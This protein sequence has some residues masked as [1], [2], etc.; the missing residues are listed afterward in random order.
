[1]RV[2]SSQAKRFGWIGLFA[3]LALSCAFFSPLRARVESIPAKVAKVFQASQASPTPGAHPGLSGP[4]VAIAQGNA[5][6]IFSSLLAPGRM[7]E[8]PRAE[9]LAAAEERFSHD[10]P[11]REAQGSPALT[12]EIAARL[13]ILK[14][15]APFSSEPAVQDF[16]RRR[17]HHRQE[18]W[19]VERQA[20]R[21]LDHWLSSLPEREYFHFLGHAD[22]RAVAYAHVSEAD[23]LGQVLAEVKERNPAAAA[24]LPSYND[25][26]QLICPAPD[27]FATLAAAVHWHRKSNAPFSCDDPVEGK[28]GRLLFLLRAMDFSGTTPP[29]AGAVLDNLRNPW[30]YLISRVESL[31]VDLSQTTT[32]AY[33]SKRNIRLGAAFFQESPLEA[34]EALIHEAR[35]SDADDPGHVICVQGDIP[36]VDGG[37]DE[38]LS[39]GPKAGGYSY[40]VFFWTQLAR[41]SNMNLADREF[42]YSQALASISQRFNHL[43]P[44]LAQFIDGIVGLD[45]NAHLVFL[46]PFARYSF[47][48]STMLG[49]GNHIQKLAVDDRSGGVLLFTQNLESLVWGFRQGILPYF[50][51]LVGTANLKVKFAGKLGIPNI[52]NSFT[53][54]AFIDENQ[55]V[56]YVHLKAETGERVLEEFPLGSESVKPESFCM[57]THGFNYFLSSDH[58][59]FTV[60]TRAFENRGIFPGWAQEKSWDQI[61]CGVLH[62][63]LFGISDGQ[64]YRE[65]YILGGDGVSDELSPNKTFYPVTSK[66]ELSTL[67]S[68]DSPARIYHE[69]TQARAILDQSGSLLLEDYAEQGHASRVTPFGHKLVDFSFF[70]LLGTQG[71][72]ARN[73]DTLE[74]RIFVRRCGVRNPQLDP[75]LG[76]FVGVDLENRLVFE[77]ENG[78]CIPAALPVSWA[79][80]VQSFSFIPGEPA[81]KPNGIFWS[82]EKAYYFAPLYL[83][84]TLTDGSAHLL[85]PYEG[86]DEGYNALHQ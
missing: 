35:H 38:E 69:G 49:D 74:R 24:N 39:D 30:Q 70:R 58:K 1:M 44:R 3:A 21:N 72:L 29:G 82:T 16:L 56:H 73:Q 17:V 78:E 42:V 75:W 25:Y 8:V 51:E 66:A 77:G 32:T 81:A 23:L 62:D 45:E 67:Q 28:L 5:P 54:S 14:A 50:P 43:P 65:S 15:L 68:G 18:N 79:N 22:P 61:D 13:G 41:Q 48:I 52:E 40:G 6:E 55:A 86:W 63:S 46:H 9:V 59:L 84:V 83:S 31:D 37:C 20:L 53:Y 12:S 4:S 36:G 33:N 7:Q 80:R 71:M 11:A 47:P 19:L 34:M 27:V 26:F 2:S 76:R 60:G 85:H 10:Y 64:L 57:N